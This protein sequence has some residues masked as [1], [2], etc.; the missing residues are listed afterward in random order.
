MRVLD[1]NVNLVIV[2]A[3]N[4]AILTPNWIAEKAMH[5]PVGANFQV[6][7]DLPIANLN[8]GNARPR[9]AFEGIAVSSEPHALTFQLPYEDEERANLGVTTAANIL[10]LLSHTPVTGFGFN[11]GF[12]FDQPN[13]ALLDTFGGTA[14]LADAVADEN[15]ELVSQGWGGTVRSDRRLINVWTKYEA[16][17]VVFNVNVHTEVS[18]ASPAAAALRT[19]HLFRT[20]KDEVI[21]VVNRFDNP[22]EAAQ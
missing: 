13:Q 17:S 2:G 15:A 8:F 16:N 3:W 20:I 11:F 22:Q 9:L 14:F 7:V 5:R 6:Q 18:G 10:D 4:P 1:E 12:Q 21:G 19:E